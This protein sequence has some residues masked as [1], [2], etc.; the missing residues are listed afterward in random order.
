MLRAIFFMYIMYLII[1]P[2]VTYSLFARMSNLVP[3]NYLVN[4]MNLLR[5]NHDRFRCD[6]REVY[7]HVNEALLYHGSVS[8]WWFSCDIIIFQNVK[9]TSDCPEVLV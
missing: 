4:L 8:Y 7:I 5:A 2:Q 1:L 3:I 6:T 9:N